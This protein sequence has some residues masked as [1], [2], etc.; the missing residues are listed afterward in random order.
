MV[1]G[2][3]GEYVGRIADEVRRRPLF[4]VRSM[5]GFG[6]SR[7]NASA[8][9]ARRRRCARGA[10]WPSRFAAEDASQIVVHHKDSTFPARPH[11]GSPS[12]LAGPCDPV[13]TIR[14]RSPAAQPPGRWCV[15]GAS[16]GS[17]VINSMSVPVTFT[18]QPAARRSVTAREL[19]L[20]A[21]TG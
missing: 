9:C 7:S 21:L 16:T 8:L 17:A 5:H 2:I 4:I 11:S 1:I 6:P 10:L 20:R 3:I 15:M 19:L 18:G 12:A 14:N 13:T